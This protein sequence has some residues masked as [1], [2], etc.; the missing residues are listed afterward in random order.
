MAVEFVRYVDG[1]VNAFSTQGQ[2]SLDACSPGEYAL[3]LISRDA[4]TDPSTVASG[5]I[6]LEKHSDTMAHWLYGKTLE[7]ADCVAN[8]TVAQWASS[9]KALAH[10][11]IYSGVESV[12]AEKGAFGTGDGTTIDCGSVTTSEVMVVALTAMYSTASR[13]VGNVEGFTERRERG[14]T[15]PDF[16]HQIGDTNGA[17]G[18]GSCAPDYTIDSGNSATYRG[19]FIVELAGEGEPPAATAFM[20]PRWPG[21]W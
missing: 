14:S 7:E 11:V 12:D 13:T 5:W 4:T 16:W 18:G 9:G 1:T 8:R 3:F 20:T 15:T 2:V 21:V 19:G 17:W 10:A 6:L